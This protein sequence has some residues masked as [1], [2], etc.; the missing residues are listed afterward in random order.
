MSEQKR[1]SETLHAAF[2]FKEL[3]SVSTSLH[4]SPH[5]GCP[6]PRRDGSVCLLRARAR[7]EYDGTVPRRPH[8]V[9]FSVS[10]SSHHW[11]SYFRCSS[12]AADLVVG[13]YYGGG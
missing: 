2:S 8:N 3:D 7:Q 9:R 4:A 1:W 12:N 10:E 13:V 11:L 5:S 6:I